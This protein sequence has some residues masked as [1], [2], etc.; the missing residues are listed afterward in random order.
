MDEEQLIS[1]VRERGGFDG[2]ADALRATRATLLALGERLRDDER[3]ALAREL[4]TELR[5]ALERCAYLGDFDREELFAR[6]ALH[7]NVSRG[8]AAELAEVACRALGELL[9]TPPRPKT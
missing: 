1:R 2:R 5:P 7:A 8:F 6:V 9:S 3:R 4:P